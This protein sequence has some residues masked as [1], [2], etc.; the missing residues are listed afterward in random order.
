[1][2]LITVLRSPDGLIVEVK[3]G[4]DSQRILSLQAAGQA[5]PRPLLVRAVVDTGSDI[6]CVAASVL[7]Q[8][9]LSPARSATTTTT[10]GAQ[11]VRLFKVSLSIQQTGGSGAI[12]AVPDLTVMELMH[13]LPN[14]E[15]LIGLDILD[16]CLLVV[17]GPAQ[18][19]T[20]SF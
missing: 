17:N 15:A 13:S 2:P 14:I 4:P 11:Q 1:M 10:A 6:S 7:T 8:L 3:I 12:Y 16:E 5:V 20:L 9:G 18:H 19:F